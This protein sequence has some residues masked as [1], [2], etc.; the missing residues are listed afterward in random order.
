LKLKYR[1]FEELHNLDAPREIVPVI[2]DL[3]NPTSVVDVGCGLGTFIHVF[4]DTGVADALG[5]D[6]SWCN[7]ELLFKYINKEEFLEKDLEQIIRIDKKFDLVVCLEVAEHLTEKRADSFVLDLILLGDV[8]LF[9]AAIP[10]MGG[11]NHINEQWPDYWMKKFESHGYVAHDIL[12][13]F[14]WNNDRI[15]WWYRQNMLFFTTRE[16]QFKSKLALNYNI[17]GTLIHPELFTSKTQTIDYIVRGRSSIYYYFK[18]LVK[19]V[20]NK[21]GLYK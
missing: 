2:M 19:A 16:Y 4:K 5:I 3:V 8:I 18:L 13:P 6:G 1:H 21:C 11:I 9:S 15:W 14:F 10:K 17:I 20:L 7:K 12:K